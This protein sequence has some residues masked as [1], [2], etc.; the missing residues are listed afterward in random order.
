MAVCVAQ[1]YFSMTSPL[2]VVIWSLGIG[3]R[4][5]ALYD[6][7]YLGLACRGRYEFP[8]NSR[9]TP[10]AGIIS[11]S[12][13]LSLPGLL[14]KKLFIFAPA[15]TRIPGG[16]AEWSNAA[17]LKT[18]EGQTSGGSNPSSSAK[19]NASQKVRRFLFPKA[20][21][22]SFQLAKGNKKS[23]RRKP[24][25]VLLCRISFQGSRAQ[26]VIPSQMIETPVL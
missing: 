16:M 14:S 19:Q 3:P 26:R 9:N 17:V 25:G 23:E 2:C 13:I 22:A 12:Q 24:L 21:K 20:R 11:P 10:A 8:F 7:M 18:V 4:T 1:P 15:K 6:F 5:A